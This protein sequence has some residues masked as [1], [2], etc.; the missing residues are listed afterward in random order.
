MLNV[1]HDWQVLDARGQVVATL[2]DT[3]DLI[4]FGVWSANGAQVCQ[5]SLGGALQWQVT[6]I[7]V[8]QRAD[9]VAQ[10]VAVRE[11]PYPPL[12]SIVACSPA[13]RRA[14][15]VEPLTDQV[16][17]PRNAERVALV[18]DLADGRIL[19]RVAVGDP[20]H[21]LVVSPDGR[22][23]AT[24]DYQQGKSTIVDLSTGKAVRTTK[25]EVRGF[26][27]DGSRLVENS[28]FQ[29][30]NRGGASTT[31]IVDVRS[32]QVRYSQPGWTNTVRSRPGSADLA[33]VVLPVVP[34]DSYGPG[35]LVIVPAVGYKTL[36]PG[37]TMY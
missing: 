31:R 33:M 35:D 21:G 32:G 26:S 6:V 1:R 37:V 12:V 36:V 29:L 34:R 14:V 18:V 30:R 2:P 10:T 24:V 28:L 27:A 4:G 11:V 3:M 15:L 9:S 19:A 25:S 8:P 23:L 20:S 16:P 7:D 17:A 13:A 5:L 22:Y